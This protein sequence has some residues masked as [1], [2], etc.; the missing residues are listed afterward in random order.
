MSSA[1]PN[2]LSVEECLGLQDNAIFCDGTWFHKGTRN[3]RAE[4]Q[5]GPRIR[6]ARHVDMSDIATTKDLFP[7]LNPKG[8][9]AMLPPE[10][11]FAAT[12]DAFN[13]TNTDHVIVYGKNGAL[14][15]PRT[16]FL[17][18]HFGHINVSLMQGS[19]EE[20]IAAGGAIETTPITVPFAKD[21]LENSS[22]SPCYKIDRQQNVVDME[23]MRNIVEDDD[24]IIL[25]P[26]GSSFVKGYIP[27]AKHI[28]YS[29]LTMEDNGLKLKSRKELMEIFE[30]AGV[31]V[32]APQ[33]IVC[34]CGSG[35][36]VCHLVL[37]LE[38]CGRTD[39]TFIYDGSW[40]EWKSDP[41]T[42]K[43]LPEQ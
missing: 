7:E 17:F 28:P 10:H 9:L 22:V 25:D 40:Q 12:M 26:R 16:W 20:W 19:L 6:G 39:N 42:P 14:F 18:K 36:S 32:H 33:D 27:G 3:G 5:E 1:K 13:I 2:L 23:Q 29:S 43:V 11:L 38:E 31:D 37:A 30:Q 8:L 21:I 15:T 4:F 24:T 41:N 34:S 35:V